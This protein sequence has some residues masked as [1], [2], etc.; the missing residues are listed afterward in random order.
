MD[1]TRGMDVPSLSFRE[2]TSCD[3]TFALLAIL[4]A[5]ML[6]PR[7]GSKFVCVMRLPG[8]EQEI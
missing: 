6:L 8:I 4:V 1:F 7:L 3:A 2:G 5:T